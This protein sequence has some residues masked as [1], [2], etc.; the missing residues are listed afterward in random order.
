MK[1]FLL[2][3]LILLSI[4][5]A[6]AFAYN[7]CREIYKEYDTEIFSKY[8][9]S[10]GNGRDVYLVLRCTS[11]CYQLSMGG[12]KHGSATL[13]GT[14]KPEGSW[15]YNACGASAETAS[16]GSSTSDVFG[17]MMS[18]CNA[19]E[20]REID[21]KNARINDENESIK[22]KN[23][24]ALTGY[25]KSSNDLKDKAKERIETIRPF[26]ELLDSTKEEEKQAACL[27]RVVALY[28]SSIKKLN[29]S[30]SQYKKAMKSSSSV[31]TYG[32][33]GIDYYNSGID[34]FNKAANSTGKCLDGEESSS[35]EKVEDE[36]L[37][38]TDT[39]EKQVFSPPSNVRETPW[40]KIVCSVKKKQTIDVSTPVK[41]R[42]GKLWY[43]TD[44][45]GKPGYIHQSQVK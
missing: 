43:P 40:G 37:S 7:G 16:Y 15:R 27:K 3:Q 34:R 13:C 1:I 39:T 32:E 35:D 12:D 45:C 14:K 19:V 22:K 9:L 18:Q 6:N 8:N 10:I 24:A 20:N 2:L 26:L 42:K 4:Y 38:E 25:I 44:V 31:V 17:L 30:I 5:S 28:E 23:H 21:R 41:G 11:D 33:K 29:S 36:A